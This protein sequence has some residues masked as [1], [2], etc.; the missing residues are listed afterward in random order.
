MKRICLFCLLT[1]CVVAVIRLAGAPQEERETVRAGERFDS[2]LKRLKPELER[3]SPEERER[4]IKE[5]QDK[6]VAIPGWWEPR[7]APA[8]RATEVAEQQKRYLDRL[9]AMKP[10][11]DKLGAEERVKRMEQ[12]KKEIFKEPDEDLQ[13]PRNDD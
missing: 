12:V 1:L 13:A 8:P 11:L 3:L 10:E 7:F 5:I 2:E 4:R 9:G 6:I